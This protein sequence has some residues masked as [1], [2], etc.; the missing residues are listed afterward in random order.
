[1]IDEIRAILADHDLA[2]V[3]TEPDPD[4]AATDVAEVGSAPAARA[5]RCSSLVG[6]RFGRAP[7][8]GRAASDAMRFGPG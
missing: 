7:T 2:T 5:H 8:A 3:T 4:A 6:A 1:M